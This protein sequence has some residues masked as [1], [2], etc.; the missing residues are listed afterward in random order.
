[1]RFTAVGLI[2]P[3]VVCNTLVSVQFGNSR[4]VAE[5]V[6]LTANPPAGHAAVVAVEHVTVTLVPEATAGEQQEVQ[7]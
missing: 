1:V 4:S 3:T 7:G 5:A 6:T 2:T